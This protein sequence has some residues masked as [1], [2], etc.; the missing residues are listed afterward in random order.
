MLRDSSVCVQASCE[1]VAEVAAASM[2]LASLVKE[3]PAQMTLIAIQLAWTAQVE[4]TI[5]AAKSQ[6]S[7]IS[8][9]AKQQLMVLAE[10]S[11][12]CLSDLG[13]DMNRCAV[14]HLP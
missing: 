2:H 3:Q 13:S 12:W 10:L 11:S 14:L 1:S 7:A 4:A 5:T 8:D 6:K 9:T